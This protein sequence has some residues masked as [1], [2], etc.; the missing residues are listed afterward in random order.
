MS[1]LTR[2]RKAQTVDRLLG[3]SQRLGLL[4]NRA[5]SGNGPKVTV[6]G[7]SLH[8]FGSCSYMGLETHARLVEA[9]HEALDGYGTQFSFSR[10]YL[11]LPLYATLETLLDR[12]TGR[13]ALVT[14]TTSLGHMAALPVLVGDG[15]L[16]LIDQLAHASLHLATELL[17]GTPVER[18]RH[19]RMDQLE[20]VL[21]RRGAAHQ[22][23]WY[24]CDGV[25]SMLGD[26]APF[27]A[28]D[29]LL[30]RYPQLHIYCD[31]AHAVSWAGLHGRGA[32]LQ[33]L[34]H[35]DRVIVALSLNKAF[36]AAGGALALPDAAMR[37]RIRRC[38]GPMLFSGPIQPPMLGAAIASAELHLETAF[39]LLQDE[40]D[41]R[42]RVAQ[43]AIDRHGLRTANRD[44]TPIFMV[45]F[46]APAQLHRAL[47]A[48]R[49]EGYYCC[50]STFPAVPLDKPSLRFT[51]SRHNSLEDIKEFISVLAKIVQGS[52]SKPAIAISA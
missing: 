46:E 37:T 50:L 48:I 29:G 28:L 12:L 47:A 2:S 11:E 10:A 23:I 17:K 31:D 4:M 38:G 7:R 49:D 18:M 40:L 5:G 9:A 3:E 26:F 34:G 13:H 42:I 20:D 27:A 41:L 33:H 21:E 24:I 16:V 30:N 19:N 43:E 36:S 22:R 51:V 44:H 14:P 6:E 15:D 32:A 45:Q 1:K 39:P 35:H 25:Y 52:T 8:N